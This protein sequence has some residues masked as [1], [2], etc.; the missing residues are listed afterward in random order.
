MAWWGA[1]LAVAACLAL[2]ATA[3]AAGAPEVAALQVALRAHGAYVG[4]VDG[5]AGPATAAA[6]VRFQRRM[7]LEPDGIVGPRTRRALGRLGSPRLGARTLRRGGVGGDVAALQ[8]ALAWHGAPSGTFDGRFGWRLHAALR[9]FQSARRLP[10]DGI[11]GRGTFVA[12]RRP[13]LSIGRALVAPVALSPSYGFGPRRGS[14][15]AGVDYPAARGTPVA[16]AAEGRV[17]FA[18]WRAGGHGLT[19]VLA[20]G[21]G[22]RTLYT[23]LSSTSVGLG[24]RV[25]A[26]ATVGRVGSTGRSTG[27]H[28]HFEV[29]VRG[30]AVDPLPA[31]LDGPS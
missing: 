6:I 27:P 22:L 10:V 4:E 5:V 3:G 17:T 24:T 30:L 29:R 14:F 9:R 31:L 26:G 23:H 8:F 21:G 19:V 16:A 18:G 28:L 13:H 1:V 25:A 12:L 11:A 20:H 15:H 2:P 7:H